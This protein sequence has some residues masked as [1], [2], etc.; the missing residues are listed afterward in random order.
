MEIPG[1][2]ADLPKDVFMKVSELYSLDL[3]ELRSEL[4]RFAKSYPR[5]RQS[6]TEEVSGVTEGCE[7]E[8]LNKDSFLTVVKVLNK[9][10]LETAFPNLAQVYR[11]LASLPVGSTK[12][13]RCF[14]KLKI[15]KNRLRSS[16]GQSRLESLLLL[17]IEKDMIDLI[18]HAAVIKKFAKTKLLQ[19]LIFA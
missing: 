13:E 4:V 18:D 8:M 2:V 16:M 1:N 15:L 10:N 17:S 3:S 19:N 12:C 5:L 6:L 14:S 7:C 9:H 11:K